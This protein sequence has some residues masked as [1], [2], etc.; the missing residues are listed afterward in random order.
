MR[1]LW[2]DRQNRSHNVS[3]K[4]KRIRCLSEFWQTRAE[5]QKPWKLRHPNCANNVLSHGCASIPSTNF[6]III[7]GGTLK[8]VTSLNK[9][10][11]PF[12]LSDNGIWSSPSVSSLSDYSIWKS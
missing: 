5:Q 8:T 3:Q 1:A 4:V 11:R 7:S 10:V 6:R 12:F 9:E 2:S